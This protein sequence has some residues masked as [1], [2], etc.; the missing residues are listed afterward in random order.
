MQPLWDSYQRAQD[1]HL[2]IQRIT[3]TTTATVTTTGTKTGGSVSTAKVEKDF[4]VTPADFGYWRP[5]VVDYHY[6]D[7]TAPRTTYET[8][9]VDPDLTATAQ[10]PQQQQ[11]QQQQQQQATTGLVRIKENEKGC[12]PFTSSQSSRIRDNI[13]VVDRGGCLFILK[14]F[15]AQAAGAHGIVVINWDETSFAMTGP[16]PEEIAAATATTTTTTEAGSATEGKKDAPQMGEG[17]PEDA[18][19]IHSVMIGL[20][21]GQ[22]LLDWIREAAEAE[23]TEAEAPNSSSSSNAPGTETANVTV[24]STTK[25]RSGLVAGFVQRKLTKE[26]LANAR[27]S[28]NS[29]PIVNIH[30]ISVPMATFG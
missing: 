8:I 25:V 1:A 16:T 13:L 15:Y 23:A 11:E 10:P 4:L 19:D 18:I 20:S 27:L 3:T 30:S 14:A 21:E 28:Y 9:L 5:S 24:T 29:L 2:R 12:R 22:V 7:S 26:Q 6:I 17:I